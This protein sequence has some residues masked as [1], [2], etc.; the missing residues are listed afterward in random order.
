MPARCPTCHATYDDATS[1]CTHDGTRLV[2]QPAPAAAPNHT[3]LILTVLGALVVVLAG[4]VAVLVLRE[5]EVVVVSEPAAATQT[6]VHGGGVDFGEPFGDPEAVG[7][8]DRDLVAVGS[9]PR[10][11]APSYGPTRVTTDG[12]GLLLRAGPSR[13]DAVLGKMLPGDVVTTERCLSGP[14]GRRWCQVV[15]GGIRGW[16]LDAYLDVGA[17]AYDSDSGLEQAFAASDPMGRYVS[18]DGYEVSFV[19]LRARPFTGGEVLTRM[20]PG[21]S[22]YVAR[23]LPYGWSLGGAAIEG[24]WCF[25]T[26]EQDGR[27]LSGW[28]SD[29]ALRW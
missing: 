11:A 15:Y 14:P 5:P 26:A 7:V 19:N 23:C 2:R 17:E 28:A 1:F 27:S 3:G 22:V 4:T 16:A 13:A 8:P 18:I 6:D 21:A 9:A 24:R 25:V 20:R 12:A 29:G 10:P